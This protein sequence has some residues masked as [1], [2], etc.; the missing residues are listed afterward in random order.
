MRPIWNPL[1]ELEA[2]R[3]EVNRVFEG[4]SG[5]EGPSTSAFLPGRAARR[6]PLMNVSEDEEA[7]YVDA[8][9]PGL[10][11]ES[12]DV[13]L[14]GNILTVSGEKESM[15]EGEPQ[16]YHREERAAG[17]FSRTLRLDFHLDRD[18]VSA[19]YTDGILHVTLPKAEEARPKKID[20]QVE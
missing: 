3:N 5:G 16:T 10:N 11:A 19:E 18:G 13:S 12:L 4:W 20:V 9:A 7:V 8:L 2:L 6:Y 17:N 1:R 14:Q 15:A